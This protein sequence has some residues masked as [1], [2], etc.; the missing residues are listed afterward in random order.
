MYSLFC[1]AKRF[2][3]RAIVSIKWIV[4]HHG[5]ELYLAIKCLKAIYDVLAL[6]FPQWPLPELPDLP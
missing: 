5:Q 3:H 4:L 6:L 2:A 1:R